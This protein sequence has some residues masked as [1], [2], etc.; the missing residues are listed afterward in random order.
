MS[1]VSF[2]KVKELIGEEAAQKMMEAFPCKQVYIL[3]RMPEF[4]DNKTRN[5]YIKNLFYNSGNQL[6]K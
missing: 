2:Y 1:T 3:N 5:Q 6:M 4:P